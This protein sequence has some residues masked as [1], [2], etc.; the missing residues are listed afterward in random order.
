MVYQDHRHRKISSD[1]N[2]S[3]AQDSPILDSSKPGATYFIRVTTCTLSG[4]QDRSIAQKSLISS[5][6]Q[7]ICG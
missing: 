4:N 3:R 1:R 5:S 6:F 7:S 2:S